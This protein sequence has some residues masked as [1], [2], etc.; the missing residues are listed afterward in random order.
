VS[1]LHVS[2]AAEGGYVPHSAAMLHSVLASRGESDLQVH[3]L[4]GPGLPRPDRDLLARMVDEGGGSISFHETPDERLEGLPVVEAFTGAMWYRTFLPELLP[5]VDRVLY[6]DVDTIAVDD[7]TPLWETDLSE[8]YVAAVTNVFQPGHA[9]RSADLGLPSPDVYFNSGV[10]LFNLDTMRRDARAE[11]IRECARERGGELGWPDQ[12]ALN[13]VLGTR[14]VPLHPRW[15]LMN[16]MLAFPE[17]AEVF[18]ANALEEARRRPGIRHFEGP[19]E[20][21]PWHYLCRRELRELYLDHRRRTP[22]PEVA[23]EG[24]GAGNR[25]RRLARQALTAIRPV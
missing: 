3:Y 11:A 23:L 2:C 14:R 25:L 22:W 4:H 24:A 9:A 13:L 10:L 8:H 17:A 19:G 12:D 5:D 21:K 6:L 7:L 16:S 15:N 1:V 18:G 20:N